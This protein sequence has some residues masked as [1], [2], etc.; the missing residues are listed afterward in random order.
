M[1]NLMNNATQ[2]D[3]S[4]VQK[5]SLELLK[6][7]DSICR[8]NEIK[9]SLIR[10]ALIGIKYHNGFL[11]SVPT[12][13]V[14]IPYLDFQQFKK[15][16]IESFGSSEHY[17]LLDADNCE[18]FEVLFVR[19]IK[20]SRI[21][22]PD[23][24]KQD[25]KYYAYF[26]DIYPV[27]YAGNTKAEYAK[28]EKIMRK[29]L[30]TL[31]SVKYAPE[32]FRIKNAL[33]R[34]K[35]AYYY[36]KKQPDDYLKLTEHV[37]KQTQP[38]KYVLIHSYSKVRGSVKL[39]ETYTNVVQYNFNGVDTFIPANME[40]WFNG[41][42]SKRMLYD[43]HTIPPNQASLSGPEILRRVQLVEL[44]M[45]VELD[46]ICRKHNIKYS[47]FAGT[48]LG[49]VRHKGF[50]PWDDDVDVVM[51]YDDYLKFIEI[52][53]EELDSDKY[54]IRTQETDKDMNLTFTQIKRNGTVFGRPGRDIYDTHKGVFI[55]IMPLFNGSRYGVLHKLQ[56]SL[57]RHYRV[58][59]W[60]HM[61]A[62]SERNPLLR[63]YYKTIAKPSNKVNYRKFINYATMFKRECGRI[64]HL[65]FGKRSPKNK[66]YGMKNIFDS[67]VE[68]EFEG[69]K[70]L[71]FE[72]N[73]DVLNYMYSPEYMKFPI[74]AFRYAKHLPGYIDLGQLYEF[75]N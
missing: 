42:Y 29:Y 43:L 2:P 34:L 49:A 23:D 20:K 7:V 6:L 69:Y 60:A 14:A 70:L 41:F 38:S 52:A 37:T 66:A 50:V 61:G 21:S 16:F 13:S 75:E 59:T 57:S 11:P 67:L 56:L 55:D 27:Y 71:A 48:L 12:L 4:L 32:T 63:F 25:E 15:K 5:V 44:E 39:L 65:C 73:T 74:L 8:E 51:L 10:G 58:A 17:S 36:K 46:R 40:T 26:L 3:L 31:K 64:S 33:F 68:I 72:N 19:L 18:Q 62:I 47:L 45:L 22:L 1:D 54:F 35:N 24:R 53:K 28:A 9:Y 30:K